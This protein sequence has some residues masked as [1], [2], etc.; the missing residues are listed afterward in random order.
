MNQGLSTIFPTTFH[1]LRD[2]CNVA[3]NIPTCFHTLCK[4]QKKNN[5]VRFSQKKAAP[6]QYLTQWIRIFRQSTRRHFRSR[7]DWLD[8]ST[9]WNGDDQGIQQLYRGWGQPLG[10]NLPL[11]LSQYWKCPYL[12]HFRE[13]PSYCILYSLATLR[14]RGKYDAVSSIFYSD[15]RGRAVFFVKQGEYFL[16]TPN[17]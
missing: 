10:V 5:Y 8:Q 3:P 15:P 1:N 17:S 9:H 4:R 14:R 13:S 11:L 6:R 7:R 2:L 16:G 12:L